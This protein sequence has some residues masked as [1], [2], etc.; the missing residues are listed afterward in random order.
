MTFFCF[1]HLGFWLFGVGNA[2][3]VYRG[4]S[5]AASGTATATT[6]SR[7][8]R[9]ARRR[10]RCWNCPTVDQPLRRLER[11]CPTAATGKRSTLMGRTVFAAVVG[12]M[13]PSSGSTPTATKMMTT[14]P[15]SHSAVS[16]NGQCSPV[17]S[18]P[19]TALLLPHAVIMTRDA[20]LISTSNCMLDIC[21][22]TL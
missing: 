12:I 8:K 6:S 18:L 3:D 14:R 17:P 7:R 21:C 13:Q 19:R 2:Q 15:A 4:I 5:N 16:Y 10:R 11:M 22:M 1:I 20:I 9:S